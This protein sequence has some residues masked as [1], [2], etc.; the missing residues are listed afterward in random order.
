MSP[1]EKKAAAK[2]PSHKKNADHLKL[3]LAHP[4]IERVIRDAREFLE[5]PRNGIGDSPE[6]TH[7]PGSNEYVVNAYAAMSARS[8]QI[9]ESEAFR[10]QTLSI[11]QNKEIGPVMMRKQL[12]LHYYQLPENYL[13]DTVNYIIDFCD[14]PA[15]YG[16][17][18]RTY[19]VHGIL[20]APPLIF[21]EGP[22]YYTDVDKP[23]RKKSVTIT[24]YAKLTDADLKVIK[25][26]V[27]NV[28]G[29]GLP[30]FQPLSGDIDR[31]IKMEKM[32]RRYRE[33]FDTNSRKAFYRMPAKTVAK[34]IQDESGIKTT[35][36]DVHE[37]AREVKKHWKK[38]FKKL[39]NTS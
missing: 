37:G 39:G 17:S 23:M 35:A 4:E 10:Q 8:E 15:N 34:K 36:H 26:H 38:R 30:D 29:K 9:R 12:D 25:R 7:V 32:S 27:N 18:I 31:K 24:F 20:H 3:L 13:T 28:V 2:F 1:K 6:I 22:Y 14:L 21:S 16:D 5:L 11:K 19:I 33:R